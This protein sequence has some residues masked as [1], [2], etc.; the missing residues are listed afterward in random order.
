MTPTSELNPAELLKLL[1]QRRDIRG[2]RFNNQPVSE[3]NIDLLLQAASLAPSVGYSQPWEFV[4]I[5]DNSTKQ[6]VKASFDLANSA[7]ADQFN[8]ARQRQ[9]QQLRLEGIVDADLNIAVFYTP[10]DQPV[11]GQASMPQVGEYSVVCAIQNLWL[12]ARTLGLGLGWVSIIDPEQVKK[13]VNAP[14]GHKLIAY[15][16][17]GH[18]EEFGDRPE[19]ETLGW[20]E[21]KPIKECVIK[22]RYADTSNGTA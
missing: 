15:L 21:K 8:D 12:M 9:Y 14:A 22:E 20:A 18:V 7:A 4:L 19:L 2:N 17:V 6:R 11:L 1:G 13:T 5:R 3:Q 10:S 16:C